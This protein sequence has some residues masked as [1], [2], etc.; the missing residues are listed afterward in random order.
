[1][2]K[3]IVD[4]LG[5]VYRDYRPHIE[6]GLWPKGRGRYYVEVD[7]KGVDYRT[8]EAIAEDIKARLEQN[9]MWYR[10]LGPLKHVV[11]KYRGKAWRF[12]AR[13]RDFTNPPY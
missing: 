11:L 7:I 2:A 6:W 3:H 12:C 5:E 1:M 4:V 9:G 13:V 10:Q 8:A